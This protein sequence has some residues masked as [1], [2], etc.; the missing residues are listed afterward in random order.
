MSLINKYQS[1]N[2]QEKR[3]K[4]KPSI[5]QTCSIC[6]TNI[7]IIRSQQ[8]QIDN[9]KTQNELLNKTI[10]ELSQV[11]IISNEYTEDIQKLKSS[12]EDLERM[13]FETLETLYEIQPETPK[14]T[15]KIQELT[16]KT[17][18]IKTKKYIPINIPPAQSIRRVNS[19]AIVKKEII[20]QPEIRRAN[21]NII[22][23]TPQQPQQP[24]Q[25]KSPQLKR[26][27]TTSKMPNI[28]QSKPKVTTR[29]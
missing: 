27:L 9:L 10:Q 2:K 11:P 18:E 17:E 3:F 5:K 19:S 23:Y 24:Q 7:E 1:I 4:L 21:S 16:Q 26:Q 25:P 22:K 12:F 29:K 28:T 13:N 6:N 8:Q 15:E 20:R 14:H